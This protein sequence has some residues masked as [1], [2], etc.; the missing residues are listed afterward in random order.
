M[1]RCADDGDARSSAVAVC[2][3]STGASVHVV[4]GRI[5]VSG[6]ED[7]GTCGA[8]SGLR[9]V[10]GDSSVLVGNLFMKKNVQIV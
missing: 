7:G 8:D 1:A 4:G 9:Y 3:Q 10:G 6:A 2:H 5:G